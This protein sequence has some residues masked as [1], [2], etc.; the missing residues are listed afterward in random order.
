MVKVIKGTISSN[1]MYPALRMGWDVRAELSDKN[2]IK[3]GDI[4][5]FGA[6]ALTCH[7]VIGKVKFFNLTY[8]IHKGDNSSVGGIFAAKGKI[9]RVVEVF[10]ENKEKVNETIWAG[11][12]FEKP[13][14]LARIYL[15]LYLM[16]RYIFLQKTSRL[17]MYMNMLF[18]KFMLRHKPADI[19]K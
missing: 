5:I 14:N 8:L 10:N 7:K 12:C 13:G 3:P 17:T 2:N 15:I 9:S 11:S 19:K 4:V 18:W 1:S 6:D 16:K